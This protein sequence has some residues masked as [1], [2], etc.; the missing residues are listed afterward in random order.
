M[1]MQKILSRALL[2]CYLAILIWVV[3]FKFSHH[4]ASLLDHSYRSLNLIPF[5][6]P[7]MVNGQASFGEVLYNCLFFIPFGLLL[8][9]NFKKAGFC[10]KLAIILIS[11]LSAEI[12]QYIFAIGA[13]DITDLITNTTGG[14]LGLTLYEL[15]LR[16]LGN[17]RSDRL[18]ILAGVLLLL[19]FLS[20]EVAHLSRKLLGRF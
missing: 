2:A 12:V 1:M 11:S 15:S 18:I 10:P 17:P 16:I 14:F 20:I 9:L 5:A 3:M 19:I 6:A 4:P 8:S 7:K 13:T